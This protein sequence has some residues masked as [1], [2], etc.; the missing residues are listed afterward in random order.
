[1]QTNFGFKELFNLNETTFF[2][3]HGSYGACPKIIHDKKVKLMLEM[4][5]EPDKWF[6]F[7]SI[8]YWNKSRARLADYLRIDVANL[9]LCQNATESVNV[10]LK[11]VTFRRDHAILATEYTYGAVLNSIDYVA[12]YRLDK[13]HQVPV[14][15]VACRFP[16]LSE[17]ALLEEFEKTCRHIVEEKRLKI[18]VAV[19]DHISSASAMLYPVEK[20]NKII[21]KWS[22]SC[23]DAGLGIMS[24]SNSKLSMH[25]HLH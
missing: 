9:V 13:D 22:A 15:K 4:E 3:N 16:V 6:R 18:R 24:K 19:I 10:A 20:I 25:S 8:D 1:M 21:R 14:F 23:Q 7:T 12:K 11:S 17:A 5:S 2:T